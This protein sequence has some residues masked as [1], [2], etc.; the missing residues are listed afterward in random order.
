M[1]NRLTVTTA[2]AVLLASVSL[3][4]LLQG[5]AWFWAGAGAI[6]IA[7]AAG[8]VTRL[9]ALPAATVA[10][11]LAL[12]A[13]A[14][15]LNGLGWY[16][17]LLGTAIVLIA[18]LSVTRW[19]LLPVAATLIT[20]LASQ[21]IYLNLA[22]A[23]S[24]DRTKIVPTVTSLRYLWIQ[25]G[26]GIGER[27]YA[28]PVP[29]IHGAVLLA[30]AGIGLMAV[31]ADLIAVRL[32]S[33]AI[34]GLPLL[35]LFSVPITTSAKQG[36]VGATVTFCL[37]MT[38][39]L[40]I[41]AADGRERLRIWGRLVTLWQTGRGGQE[42][43]KGPDTRALAAAGRR[44][45]LAAISLA[46]FIPLLLP[47]L[48]VHKL[49]N[50]HGSAGGGTGTVALPR[51]LVQLQNQLLPGK[52]V[53]VLTYK[54]SNPDA[55]TQYLQVYVLNYNGAKGDWEL[56]L[57]SGSVPVSRSAL[58]PPPGLANDPYQP[59]RT[60]VTLAK[61]LTGYTSGF[62]F[63][64]LP[65]APKTLQ[66]KGDWRADK[67]TLMVSSGQDK[68][69][70]LTYQ[71]SSDDVQP[72]PEQIA[73]A[74]P[75]TR[76]IIHQ[77][78]PYRSALN[79]KLRA[80]ARRVTAHAANPYQKAVAL[81][82][83]FTK[84]GRFIYSLQAGDP[85]TPAGLLKFLTK[86]RV[87][88]CQQFAFAMAV[89]ARLDGIPS[90]VAVGYTAGTR[91]RNG[92]WQVTTADAHAW[93]ELYFQ[94]A[95]W[96]RFEPTPGGADGQGTAIAPVYAAK[97]TTAGGGGATSVLPPT[98]GSSS[99]G[100]G[101]STG[102]NLL[103][104][105]KNPELG[106]GGSASPT[107]QGSSVPVVPIVLA[108]LLVAALVPRTTRSVSRWR[109]WRQ[110]SDDSGAANAAWRE[111]RDDLTDYGISWRLSDSPRAVSRRLGGLLQLDP[112]AQQALDRITGAEERARY[113]K[114]AQAPDTLRA[115]VGVIRR[116]LA[117]DAT[118]GA[119][120]RARLL[121]PSAVTPVVAGLGQALD[122]FGWL[123][124]LGLRVRKLGRESAP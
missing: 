88:Y 35:A 42:T 1:N 18:A 103:G 38:G 101:A 3:Y 79:G 77:Y 29:G 86:D 60:S 104:N 17:G 25:A 44:I 23:G 84:P 10:T 48:K 78:L 58:P 43:V 36:A 90:R 85:G 112:Q 106:L 55:Q 113:A 40:A 120:W 100:G 122:V 46:I 30:A 5:I 115:D 41:L 2:A 82:D 14:P 98:T 83:W 20:Y 51:P 93:P 111:L 76:D 11:V 108:V 15:L 65:Y 53:P 9:S 19:R 24:V 94:G 59:V 7:A 81:E 110:A 109:R 117:A 123:D 63:L 80:I 87:G 97:T 22:F 4:P 27:I 75:A 33:P 13:V 8:T 64:P 52:H 50:G 68:L 31:M 99:P 67:A 61:G 124:A 102:K 37:G 16:W 56:P 107:G 12:V 121:P 6:V 34:A 105:K 54:T 45:G 71:V 32:R 118:R 89:L 95:G 92:T 62:N 91:Q 96:L 116:A 47:G 57:G 73:Q 49:F 119:R 74:G 28:P 70:G 114:T 26:K 39:Y 72:S 66:V 21:L 69:S